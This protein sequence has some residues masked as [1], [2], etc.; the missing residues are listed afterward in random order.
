MKHYVLGCVF[1]I[2]RVERAAHRPRYAIRQL[3]WCICVNEITVRMKS[4]CDEALGGNRYW[5]SAI[6]EC[7]S[8][9]V[10]EQVALAR[11]D[12]TDSR[13]GCAG[14]VMCFLR[15]FDA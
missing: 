4:N 1:L 6:L 9:A 2:D 13:R 3:Q 15:C 11:R 7:V 5:M 14:I 12:E 10:W 8:T